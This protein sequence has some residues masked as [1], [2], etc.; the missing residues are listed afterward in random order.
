MRAAPAVPGRCVVSAPT[1]VWKLPTTRRARLWR[2]ESQGDVFVSLVA[3]D[4]EASINLDNGSGSVLIR[5]GP[6]LI[7]S[8]FGTS[9][10]LPAVIK[11]AL[12]AE[13]E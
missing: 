2:I 13:Q 6:K 7:S 1:F 11:A 4:A 10:N 8:V 5:R 3:D 9:G 12:A